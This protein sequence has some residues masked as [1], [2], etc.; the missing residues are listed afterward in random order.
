MPK[1]LIPQTFHA[2]IH[3]HTHADARTHARTHENI[4]LNRQQDR[5][6]MMRNT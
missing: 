1:H 5:K 4:M 6:C 2:H 3:T